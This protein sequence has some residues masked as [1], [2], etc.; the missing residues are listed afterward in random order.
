[1]KKHYSTFI[2]IGLIFLLILS[3]FFAVITYRM[4][5]KKR[6]LQ[7]DLV[8]LS[9][10]K[11]GMFNIDRWK[12]KI[13]DIISV[14]IKEL[15]LSGDNREKAREKII[16]LLHTVIDEYERNYKEE[17]KRK[18]FLGISIQNGIADFLDIFESFRREIPNIADQIL[19]F[20]D[21]KENRDRIK[22]YILQQLE[23]YTDSTFQKIDYREYNRILARYAQTDE[24]NCKQEI[25]KRL[26]RI[27][28][29]LQTFYIFF[30]IIF[31]VIILL[32]IFNPFRTREVMLLYVLIALVFLILGLLLPMINI[33]AR[34]TSMDF[35]LLGQNIA[36]HDQVLYY[37]SKSILEMAKIM[38]SQGQVKIILVG[39][40]VLVFSVLF[41]LAKIFSS[42]WVLFNEKII[43]NK[44]VHFIV[45]KS[46]KWSMSDVLVVAIF[47]SY[48]GFTGIV[49]SQLAQLEKMTHRL[50]ILTTNNSE[51]QSGFF[52]FLA[53]VIVSLGISQ[54]IGN[55]LGKSGS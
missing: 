33:D 35:K 46:G 1:M 7:A 37:K 5:T 53:F 29:Q 38:L 52:F 20:L 48:I 4:E 41:P 15:K 14:K 9:D 26:N 11:Y 18:S 40:L 23:Q 47:M 10:I 49:S 32:L 16:K 22:A 36:F 44:M 12:E 43:Q 13:S 54:L 50:H 21:K 39:I 24:E 42:I 34:I 45:L 3:V 25:Q 17:N 28:K 8:E 27:K 55:R 30:S 6:V 2:A 19:G 31:L 51:L